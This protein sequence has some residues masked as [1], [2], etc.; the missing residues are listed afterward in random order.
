MNKTLLIVLIIGLALILGFGIYQLVKAPNLPES[1]TLP[2][3][4]G[5]GGEAG[6]TTSSATS[7]IKY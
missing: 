6:F 5:T 1:T 2:M 3:A 7:T 4:A